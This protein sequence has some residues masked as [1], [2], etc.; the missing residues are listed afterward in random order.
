MASKLSG[1]LRRLTG[2]G[3]TDDAAPAPSGPAVAY[4]GYEIHPAPRRQGSQWLTAGLISK[5]F[6][7]GV[8]EHHFIRAE[9][10]P[11]Q[12]DASAFAVV[13]AKQIIDERGDKLFTDRAPPPPEE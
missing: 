8:K 10:H 13:K 7:D 6:P 4:E 3:D 2:G 12:D 9:T 1:F 5:D 11:S